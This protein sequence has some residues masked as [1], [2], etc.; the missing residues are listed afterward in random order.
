MDDTPPWLDREALAGELEELSSRREEAD[1]RREAFL[2][3]A[4]GDV[5]T[6][7]RRK[8]EYQL[9]AYKARQ[10]EG[11]VLWGALGHA[12]RDL[13]DRGLDPVADGVA[14][15]G[16]AFVEWAV[17]ADALASIRS[18]DRVHLVLAR[19]FPTVPESHE[20]YATAMFGLSDDDV[21]DIRDRDRRMLDAAG[22]LR[23]GRRGATDF[24]VVACPRCGGEVPVRVPE[25]EAAEAS[26]SFAGA[27]DEM[28]EICP[29]C[30]R[31]LY[32][33]LA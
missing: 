14:E 13:A 33:V 28:R 1:A 18:P 25:G 23:R 3:A 17:D 16:T 2:E 4:D 5:E 27:D 29:H 15:R 20:P 8:R 7:E 10:Q 32:V 21:R 31:D 30:E 19:R 26:T 22:W 11:E 12:I 24:T 6:A 9:A